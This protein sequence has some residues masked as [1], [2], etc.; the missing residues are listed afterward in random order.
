MATLQRMLARFSGV[1]TVQE[2]TLTFTPG[3]EITA[4]GG[5]EIIEGVSTVVET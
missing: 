4:E 3:G 5:G 1:V 2:R